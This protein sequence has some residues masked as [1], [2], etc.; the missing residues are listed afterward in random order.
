MP[1]GY[2]D[3]ARD[4]LLAKAVRAWEDDPDLDPRALGDGSGGDNVACYLRA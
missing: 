2:E 3:E 4:A 1:D